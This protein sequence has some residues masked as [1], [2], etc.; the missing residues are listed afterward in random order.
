VLLRLERLEGRDEVLGL[1]QVEEGAVD[2]S[3][4]L[5]EEW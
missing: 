1:V 4:E 2:R 3:P 5:L